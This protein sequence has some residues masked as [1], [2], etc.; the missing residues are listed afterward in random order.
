M[1]NEKFRQQLV[2]E[3]ARL[4]HSKQETDSHRAVFVA[5]RK[6]CKG[7]IKPADLPSQ[8]EIRDELKRISSKS[9]QEDRFCVY[10]ALLLPLESVTE[11]RKLHPESDVLYHSL[12]VFE[13]AKN[14][15]PY[16]EEFLLAALLHDVGKGIDPF[17]HVAAGLEVLEEIITDRSAWLI[18][19]LVEAHD[20]QDGTLGARAKRRL[21]R[22]ESFE[23]LMLLEECDILGRV[24]GMEV[25]DLDEALD[26][27]KGLARQEG[28]F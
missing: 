4:M 15:L 14:E 28:S 8:R 3:V 26:F 9:V 5:A 17:D 20:I 10:R 21:Q 12:Q 6:L 7:W 13:L 11:N 22:N 1:P 27:L 16:D 25:L 23:E 19:H 24:P 18:E 2:N